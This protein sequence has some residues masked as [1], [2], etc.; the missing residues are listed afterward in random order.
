M[1]PI[2]EAKKTLVLFFPFSSSMQKNLGPIISEEFE[3]KLLII[4]IK[5][6]LLLFLSQQFKG[7]RSRVG[8]F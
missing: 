6:L 1:I 4:N 2:T 5:L 8:N 7:S 3:K